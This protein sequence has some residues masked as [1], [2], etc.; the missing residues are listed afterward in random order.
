M[1]GI[2]DSNVV[3][4]E[5]PL[6]QATSP[7]PK[8]T[9]LP[10]KQLGLVLFLQLAEPFTSQVISPFAPQLIRDIGITNGDETKVGNYVGFLQSLF[11]VAQALTVLHWSRLSDRIGRKPIILTGL[12]GLSASMYCFGLSTTFTGLILSRAM[13]GA[14]NGNIGVI[15]R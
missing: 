12:I 3:D 13:N 4:E 6:L 1:A 10:W 14:L 7:K 5:T 11:W 2:P 15:K 9:P 8:R